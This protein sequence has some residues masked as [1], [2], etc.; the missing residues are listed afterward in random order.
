MLTVE[1]KH[2]I[3]KSPEVIW[4][5]I[6]DFGVI[7]KWHPAVSTCTVEEHQ[8]AKQRVL[9]LVDGAKLVEQRID[10]GKTPNS[11]TYRII[12]GPLPVENYQSTL[13][14]VNT[15][16]GSEIRWTGSFVAIGCSD[17]E[18]KAVIAEIYEAGLTAVGTLLR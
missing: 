6:G 12:A 1:R 3:P 7:H 17:N 8:G 16:E 15:E 4:K 10:D 11:Y 13:A 9:L 18:A 14:V 5:T 2:A